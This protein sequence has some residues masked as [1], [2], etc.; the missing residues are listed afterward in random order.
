[1]CLVICV[2]KNNEEKQ[3]IMSKFEDISGFPGVIGAIDG[4]RIS[5]TP[6]GE[7]EADFVNRKKI[8]IRLFYKLYVVM[9]DYS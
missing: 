8:F 9:T 2:K 1:M 7:N 4:T 3:E 6:P 5:I